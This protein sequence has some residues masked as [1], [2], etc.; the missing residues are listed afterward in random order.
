MAGETYEEQVARVESMIDDDNFTRDLSQ[1]DEA[2]IAAVL[3]NAKRYAALKTAKFVAFDGFTTYSPGQPDNGMDDAV[4]S[5]R[6]A[7]EP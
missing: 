6:K 3:L 1:K 2:A 4:D 5:L 7:G